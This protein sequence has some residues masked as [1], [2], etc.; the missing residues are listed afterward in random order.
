MNKIVQVLLVY[1][2]GILYSFACDDHNTNNVLNIIPQKTYTEK[3][4]REL[5]FTQNFDT[6]LFIKNY[7]DAINNR[8]LSLLEN[9]FIEESSY[10]QLLQQLMDDGKE[11]CLY[12]EEKVDQNYF[13]NQIFNLILNNT[14]ITSIINKNN[15][16]FEGCAQ[17]PFIKMNFDVVYTRD[18]NENNVRLV[19]ILWKAYNGKF[20]VYAQVGNFFK[21]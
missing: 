8:N 18:G 14:T 17:I 13:K 3:E 9:Y 16:S 2:L 20:N 10:K 11:M 7:T 15:I 21:I 1:F 19:I 5:D 4:A 6:K 12:A